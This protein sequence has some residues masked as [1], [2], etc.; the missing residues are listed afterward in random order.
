MGWGGRDFISLANI[1]IITET[2]ENAH[3]CDDTFIYYMIDY[4]GFRYTRSN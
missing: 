4:T 2:Y 1:C 3:I